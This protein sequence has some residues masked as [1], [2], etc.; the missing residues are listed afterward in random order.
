MRIYD[1]LRLAKEFGSHFAYL[2]MEFHL[3]RSKEWIFLHLNDELVNQDDFISLLNRYKDGEPLEYIVGR[4]E[5]MG[6]EFEVGYGVLIP[7]NETEILVQK[8]LEIASKF[9]S[10]RIAEIGTGSGIVSISLALELK[11]AKIIAT[12]ISPKA[13]A[14]AKVN[15][16]KFG[17][18]IKLVES[19]YLDKIDGEF[20]IIVSNPPYIAA[21]YPLDKWVLSEPKLALI[22]GKIGDEILKD[23]AKIA[24]N[25]AK[26]LICEMG[27]DQKESMK[28]YLDE[29]GFQSDFYSD[30]AGFDRG[31]VSYNKGK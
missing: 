4:C 27:Y 6:R 3:G 24:K 11:N 1:G 28:S 14:F 9:K 12:D 20:D 23:I 5:F 26:Y 18:D 15:R 8:T 16:D 19:N 25:R 13:L 2:L 17:V 30:L 7:R 31:F 21:D 22:G 29:L 10:P